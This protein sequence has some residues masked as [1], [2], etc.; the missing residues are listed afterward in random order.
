MSEGDKVSI[1]CTSADLSR[2][3]DDDNDDDDDDDDQNNPRTNTSSSLTINRAESWLRMGE[4][5]RVRQRSR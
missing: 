2:F 3:P 1:I 4:Y 5:A